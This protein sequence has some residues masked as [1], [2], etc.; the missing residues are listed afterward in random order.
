MPNKEDAQ[1]VYGK[2]MLPI[3][4]DNEMGV[5]EWSSQSDIKLESKEARRKVQ[6]VPLA[7][8]QRTE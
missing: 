1:S 4:T 3:I 7:S 2:G 6:D 5:V 8:S